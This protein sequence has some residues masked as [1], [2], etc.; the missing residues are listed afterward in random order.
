MR[1]SDQQSTKIAEWARLG[2]KQVSMLKINFKFNETQ[3]S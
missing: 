2:L 3:A 1:N